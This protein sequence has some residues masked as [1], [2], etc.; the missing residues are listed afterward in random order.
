M[1]EALVG[2]VAGASLVDQIR[3]DIAAAGLTDVTLTKKPEYIDAMSQ[4]QDPLY[5][6]IVEE[7]PAGAKASDYITSLDISAS[8]P[9]GNTGVAR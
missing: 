6:R 3:A 8:K 9:G 7:L 1:V 5:Q 2:C 4:W